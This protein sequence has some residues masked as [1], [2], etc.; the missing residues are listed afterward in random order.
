MCVVFL[1]LAMPWMS[2]LLAAGTHDFFKIVQ[3]GKPTATIVISLEAPK[4]TKTAADWL[5]K[6]VTGTRR[7]PPRRNSRLCHLLPGAS[8]F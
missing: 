7:D 6:Y 8:N 2:R 5:V 3:Q 4:W 1:G